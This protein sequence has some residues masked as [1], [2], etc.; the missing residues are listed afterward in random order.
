MRA[1]H[2]VSAMAANVNNTVASLFVAPVKRCHGRVMGR[3]SQ[4]WQERLGQTANTAGGSARHTSVGD[5]EASELIPTIRKKTLSSSQRRLETYVC[6][7][8]IDAV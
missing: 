6:S 3:E 5:L 8:D 2:A 7:T 4:N 1:K